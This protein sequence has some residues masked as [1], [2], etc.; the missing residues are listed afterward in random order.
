VNAIAFSEFVTVRQ[1]MNVSPWEHQRS[2]DLA[3][4]HM[5]AGVSRH[6]RKRFQ[7]GS[8]C[9]VPVE[10]FGLHYRTTH[11]RADAC[12]RSIVSPMESMSRRPV[13]VSRAS[14]IVRS[15]CETHE[16]NGHASALPCRPYKSRD[17]RGSLECNE[18]GRYECQEGVGA[19]ALFMYC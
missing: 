14:T 15:T 18:T 7:F 16:K 12:T 10:L 4:E 19:T 3:E 6:S 1:G 13:G 8:V 11:R 17:A 5:D 2:V 9:T